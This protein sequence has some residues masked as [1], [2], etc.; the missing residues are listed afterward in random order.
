MERR[1]RLKK[2]GAFTFVFKRGKSCSNRDLVM[3]YARGKS[4]GIK[5]GFSISKK[6]GNAVIRNL[7]KRRLRECFRPHLGD[8]KNGMYI[9][10]ARPSAATATFQDL[11]RQTKDLLRKQHAFLEGE[12]V[13]DIAGPS[14]EQQ[15]ETKG[16]RAP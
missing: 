9:I 15:T 4:K 16:N 6:V 11:S 12:S 8:V 1:Y 10:V 7:V 14:S 13:P 2:S 3:L 5:V